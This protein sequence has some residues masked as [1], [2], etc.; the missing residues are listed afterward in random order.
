MV[1]FSEE[2]STRIPKLLPL[3]FASG[4]GAGEGGGNL[5]F[6]GEGPNLVGVNPL[7]ENRRRYPISRKFRIHIPMKLAQ[8]RGPLARLS[9]SEFI[10]IPSWHPSN[11]LKL[12]EIPRA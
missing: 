11:K 9:L 12:P 2:G 4:G 5:W 1:E 10:C 3:G 7:V 6:Q 8:D